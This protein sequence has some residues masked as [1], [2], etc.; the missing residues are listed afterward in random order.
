[1][2]VSI[3]PVRAKEH[4]QRGS[5]PEGSVLPVASGSGGLRR[6][7]SSETDTPVS[8]THG[9]K[10]RLPRSCVRTRENLVSAALGNAGVAYQKRRNKA[11]MKCVFGQFA[12]EQ[13][14]GRELALPRGATLL[15]AASASVTHHHVQLF[16]PAA[17]S[18]WPRPSA[19]QPCRAGRRSR[20]APAAKPSRRRISLSSR[21]AS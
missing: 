5:R 20:L 10:A 7:W 17:P 15:L 8:A 4:L 2:I 11:R 3:Q 21:D 13:R 19:A 6:R 18:P 1:M 9:R 14:Q 12:P 16:L